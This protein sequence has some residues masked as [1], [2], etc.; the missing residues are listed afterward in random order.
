MRIVGSRQLAVGRALTIARCGLV[1]TAYCL[2]ACSVP[3]LE[4]PACSE[5]KNAVREFYSFHF[6]NDMRFTP[7]NLKQ[8]ERFLTPEFRS[9]LAASQEGTDPFTTGSDDIPKAFR[10]GEC[11][12]ISTERTEQAVLLF[13]RTDERTEQREIK[14]ETVDRNDSW[15]IDNISR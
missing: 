12:E 3:N 1:I 8:R 4:T 13:W 11:K 10:V 2:A 9:K 14:V 7:D 6:G 5:S 15:L